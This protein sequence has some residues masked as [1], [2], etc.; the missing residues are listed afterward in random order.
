MSNSHL[1]AGGAGLAVGT[2]LPPRDAAPDLAAAAKAP[3]LPGVPLPRPVPFPAAPAS[4]GPGAPV[5][6]LAVCLAAPAF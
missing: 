6:L 4:D 3:P 2:A 5:D 1:A